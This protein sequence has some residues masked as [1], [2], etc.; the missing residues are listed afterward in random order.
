[1]CF[2]PGHRLATLYQE[3]FIILQNFKI[4]QDIIQRLEIS[5]GLSPSS[6]YDQLIGTFG[7]FGIQ[8]IQ[9]HAIGRFLNPS[10]AI[11]YRSGGRFVFNRVVSGNRFLHILKDLK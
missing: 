9:E 4:C 2:H 7:Y 5:R 10:L 11:Q 8:I 1:M 3:R 6:I